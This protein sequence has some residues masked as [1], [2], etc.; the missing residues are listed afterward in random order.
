MATQVGALLHPLRD[1]SYRL[2]HYS[3]LMDG[4]SYL[5]VSE[6]D[7]VLVGDSPADVTQLQAVRKLSAAHPEIPVIA[8]VDTCRG[9]SQYVLKEAGCVDCLGLAEPNGRLWSRIFQYCWH[10]S[11]LRRELAHASAR[12][13]W[14]QHTD[15]LTDL[16]N[17]KGMER[18]TLQRLSEIRDKDEGLQFLLIDLD[19]FVRINTTLGHGVGD[20]VLMAVG[21]CIREN[22]GSQDLVG[23]VG[24]DRFAIVLQDPSEDRAADLAETLR[25]AIGRDAIKAGDHFFSTTASIAVTTVPSTIISFDEILAQAHFVLQRSKLKGKNRVSRAASAAE[26]RMVRPGDVGHDMTRALLRGNVLRVFSQPIVNLLDGRIVSQEMLIRGP[27]GPLQSPDA[28]FRYC[29]EKDILSP[30]DLRCLKMCAKVARTTAIGGAPRYHVN[31]LPATLLQTPVDELIRVLQ[32]ENE[33]GHCCLELSEQQLLGD[34]HVLQPRVR[35][36]QEAGIRLAIDDVGFGKSHLENLVML[37]PQILKLDKRLIQGVALDPEMR[38]TLGRMLKLADVLGS[39]V[40]AEGIEDAEDYR[41]LL[42]MGVRFGQGFLFGVP[43]A[44]RGA[45]EDSTGEQ[46]QA[47]A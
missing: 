14:M 11:D 17:R 5:L 36:L 37:D 9:D 32:V 15:S 20:L 18:A 31:I 33:Y 8:L 45:L 3:H 10:E 44:C 30:V 12:M 43:K 16:L 47:Q 1:P 24:T 34:P 38:R 46:S 29:Q 26:I 35:T 21:R 23:R 6:A 40:V 41:V 13:D 22:T 2:A 19:D 4:L 28:L 27:E 39:E 25:L 7:L 42:E